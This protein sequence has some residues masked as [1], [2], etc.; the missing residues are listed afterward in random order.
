MTQ[1]I[2][3][4]WNI[5]FAHESFL[6]W[7]HFW[8]G[9]NERNKGVVVFFVAGGGGF[10]RWVT[11]SGQSGGGSRVSWVSAARERERERDW[12]TGRGDE[13]HP[14]WLRHLQHQPPRQQQLESPFRPN[15]RQMTS[16]RFLFLLLL[17]LSR[18]LLLCCWTKLHNCRYWKLL[19]GVKP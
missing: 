17:S 10:L 9:Q 4:A 2:G 1:Y 16:P 19:G 5:S 14:P 8:R 13:P 12:W 15:S 3:F 18:L 7:K 6:F 11:A